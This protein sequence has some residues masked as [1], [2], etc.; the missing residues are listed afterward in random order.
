MKKLMSVVVSVL[1]VVVADAAVE[2]YPFAFPAG[3]VGGIADRSATLLDRT[4]DA[5]GFVSA[6][7]GR[8]VAGG[9][10]IRFFGVNLTGPA[11]FMTKGDADL[12][13][14]R[15]ASLGVNCVRLHFLDKG[16]YTF[17]FATP[18]STLISA[19]T[20]ASQRTLV[21]KNLDRLEYLVAALKR[22]GVYVNLNLH[23]GRE[24]DERDG[25]P[26][27]VPHNSKIV[28]IYHPRLI[29]LQREYARMLLTHRNPY[30]GLRWCDDPVIAMIEINN[31]NDFTVPWR[32]EGTYAFGKKPGYKNHHWLTSGEYALPE[33]YL[34]ELARQ[35][36][37]PL[38]EKATADAE[39]RARFERFLA[40]TE[41]RYY[42]GMRD[43][44][45]REL[46]VRCP[47][48]GTQL[49]FSPPEVQAR[50]DYADA[51]GYWQHPEYGP[52]R[53]GALAMVNTLEVTEHLESLRAP[54][55]RGKPF[56]VSEYNHPAPNPYGAETLPL[57]VSAA[58]KYGWSG[59]FLY[60]WNHFPECVATRVELNARCPFDNLARTDLIAH[61]PAASAL[62]RGGRAEVVWNRDREGRAYVTAKGGGAEVFTG[63]PDGRTI[64]FLGGEMSFGDLALG[65]ATVSAVRN[66]GGWLLAAT[67]ETHNRG[68]RLAPVDGEHGRVS[69]VENGE[70][71]V[72]A[73]GVALTLK[74]SAGRRLRCWALA[75]D[76]TRR[77]EVPM[78]GGALALGSRFRTVWYEL[79]D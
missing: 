77:E 32:A 57:L 59:V 25:L 19:E 14:A 64:P 36:G 50:L 7:G 39:T 6:V 35:W 47:V 38:P 67:G 68:Q 41:T 24:L 17:G 44:L 58:A 18:Q 30:T 5:R 12:T 1:C 31:E 40:E 37:G 16:G 27:K 62:M 20:N 74:F 34:E 33:P 2:L 73:E 22:R 79:V 65:W 13:A 63:F 54:A 70:E 3:A 4:I 43:F 45:V 60:T 78:K 52:M 76:G 49:E 69:L 71:T 28:D 21:A 10:E 15:L 26:A 66:G 53:Y 8:F 11:N 48:S 72:V 46:G 55:V 51:H 61:M 56:T 23:V 42:T 29:E 75:P 9:E